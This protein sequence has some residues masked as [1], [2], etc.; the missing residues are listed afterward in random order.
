MTSVRS[1]EDPMG[2]RE[3]PTEEIHVEKKGSFGPGASLKEGIR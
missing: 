2:A 3:V 1:K